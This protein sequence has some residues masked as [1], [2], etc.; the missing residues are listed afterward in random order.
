VLGVGELIAHSDQPV[1]LAFW[2]P[3]LI[4]G[5]ALVL[6]GVFG[7]SRARTKLVVAGALLGVIAT[8]WTLIVPVLSIVLVVLTFN[9]GQRKPAA[10]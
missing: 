5:G 9:G 7:R 1:S 4:G 2:A 8:A 10:P 6:Y 3:S